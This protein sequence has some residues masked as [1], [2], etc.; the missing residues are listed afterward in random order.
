MGFIRKQE[1]KFA[2]KLLKMRYKQE[3]K[4]LPEEKELRRH[5]EKVVSEAHS[6]ARRRGG[7]VA[8]IIRDMF[9]SK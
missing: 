4:E 9:S 1:E 6:I 8:S 3:G 5:A 7:N 2:L